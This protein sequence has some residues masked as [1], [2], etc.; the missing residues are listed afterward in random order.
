M[1]E[2]MSAKLTRA[3]FEELLVLV[4]SEIVRANN[5]VDPNAESASAHEAL[6]A[7]ID[8]G[9]AARTAF[10]ALWRID[11]AYTNY[12]RSVDED[13]DQSAAYDALVKAVAAA[14]AAQPEGWE[15]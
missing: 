5:A 2:A 1:G 6:R 4:D 9:A 8:I 11:K 13:E 10:D 12:L 7:L 15:K 14:R 3:E